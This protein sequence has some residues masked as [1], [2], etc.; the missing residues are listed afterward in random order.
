V[1]RLLTLG[2]L[3]FLRDGP[4]ADSIHLQPKRF[5][6]LAFLALAAR[7]GW[8]QRDTLL[9][10]FW[11][12]GDREHARRCLRQALFHLRN[13]LGDGV[14]LNRGRDGI[15]LAPGRLWCD[16]VA[17]D[18][19]LLAKRL[20]EALELYRGDFLPGVFAEGG[21]AAMEEWVEQTRRRLRTAVVAAAW[22]LAEAEAGAGRL[23][24]ALELA[25]R[26][27]MLAPD[28]EP[29]L[30]RHVSLLARAGDAAAALDACADFRRRLRR[31]YDAEPSAETLALVRALREG[32]SP[33]QSAVIASVE[34]RTI[35]PSV[36]PPASAARRL[37][38]LVQP[39]RSRRL[40]LA[41]SA[42]AG[43]VLAGPV[44]RGLLDGGNRRLMLAQFTNHT[45]DSLLGATVT[46][47]VRA[48]LSKVARVDL[49]DARAVRLP[50]PSAPRPAGPILV[51][52]TGDVAPM[53][54]GFAV[55]A[56]LVSAQGGRLL[57]VVQEEAA[58]TS[59]LLPTVRRLTR[60]LQSN[61]RETFEPVDNRSLRQRVAGWLGSQSRPGLP[62]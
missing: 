20:R 31:E 18:A 42:F 59:A 61:V 54:S 35:V 57:G 7:D 28:D 5:A 51:L 10:M 47:L 43:L 49:A 52:V 21:G 19:A 25:L 53:G 45:R 44:A 24:A 58:D 8:Q 27:R 62:P 23:A 48:E 38:A 50:S 4:P 17:L 39:A 16:A 13:E 26:A 22:D 36:Q 30:R 15:T 41:L 6:L 55:S 32:R 34:R 9:A 60:R 33:G 14:I 11:P 12:R 1:L 56:R 46:E 40:A 3:Q 29:G 37:G 2:R